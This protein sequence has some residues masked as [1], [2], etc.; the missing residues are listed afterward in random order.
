[1]TGADSALTAVDSVQLPQ[2]HLPRDESGGVVAGVLNA[3][4]GVAES[5]F[6]ALLAP[7][8]ML[9]DQARSTAKA[10]LESAKAH[11]QEGAEFAQ[12][13]QDFA[14]QAITSLTDRIASF[15]AGLAKVENGGQ[16]IDLM[17]HQVTEMLGIPGGVGLEDARK[18]WDHIG[19]LITQGQGMAQDLL[20]RAQATPAGGGP[21]A[22][23][24]VPAPQADLPDGDEDPSP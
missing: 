20:R 21:A 13:L 11:A 2:I 14:Q 8:R 12:F 15:S 10:P 19:E 6:Q 18:E 3:G 17:L 7:P 23:P 22:T 24:T 4:A 5:A 9:L 1:M 16:F